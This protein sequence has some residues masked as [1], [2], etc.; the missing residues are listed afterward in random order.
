M[1]A[2]DI[3]RLAVLE[4]K[5]RA[6]EEDMHDMRQKIDEMHAVLMQAKG[7]KWAILAMATLGGALA[8]L[9]TKLLILIRS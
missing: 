6:A 1:T 3:E 5:A 9:G 7:A 8:G 4:E 2:S